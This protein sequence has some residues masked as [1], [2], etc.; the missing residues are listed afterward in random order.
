VVLVQHDEVVQALSAKRA[1]DSLDLRVHVRRQL[2][3]VAAIR[4]DSMYY[5]P[6]QDG[7]EQKAEDFEHAFSIVDRRPSE[8]LPSHSRLVAVARFG[9][10][11]VILHAA[12]AA[13]LWRLRGEQPTVDEKRGAEEVDDEG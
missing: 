10:S 8:V 13:C 2:P 4:S 9:Q 1:D 12:H 7:G 11:T 5:N 6:G 3:A